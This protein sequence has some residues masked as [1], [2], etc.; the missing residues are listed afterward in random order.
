M[1]SPRPVLLQ[2]GERVDD[3]AVDR[4]R[5]LAPS[6]NQHVERV[7]PRLALRL[8]EL[9]ADRV[10]GHH[11]APAEIAPGLLERHRHTAHPRR[12]QPVGQTGV[13]VLLV[14]QAR[15][16][17][18]HRRQDQG[19]GGIAADPDHHSRSLAHE[20]PDRL[21]E[22]GHRP[23]DPAYPPGQRLAHD[24]AAPDGDQPVPVR[25]Q[26]RPLQAR[27]RT[28]EHDLDPRA[29][30]LDLLGDRDA[31]VQV[32]SGSASGDDDR[33]G[34]RRIART[35]AARCSAAPRGRTD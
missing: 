9:G 23:S 25:G 8:T 4:L 32:P 31:G 27:A 18:H 3:R 30:R 21:G 26:D 5:P 28:R 15:D 6:E 1:A 22:A 11:A 16:A 13:V 7:A 10:P 2:V 29:P 14:D 33:V 20:R 24:T 19:P 35:N 12:Q 17:Q 34:H